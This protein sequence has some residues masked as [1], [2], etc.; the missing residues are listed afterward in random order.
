M[1]I[2]NYEKNVGITFIII[3]TLIIEIIIFVY[4]IK[5]KIYSYQQLNTIVLKDNIVLSVVTKEERKQLYKNT[6][7]FFKDKKVKYK[8]IEDKGVVITKDDKKYYEI[9][10]SFKFDKK[11]KSNDTIPVSLHDKKIRT[12]EI[13]K[14]IWDGD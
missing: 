9:L 8:I 13:F 11:Y 6:R 2:R 5:D 14:L 3:I 7:L 12:I 1:K 4:M 10:L